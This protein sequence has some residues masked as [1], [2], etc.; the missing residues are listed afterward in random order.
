MQRAGRI[1]RDEL[2]VDL[3]A[4]AELAPAVAVTGARG[5][6][7]TER[8]SC[9]LGQPEIDEA[10]PGDLGLRTTVPSGSGARRAPVRQ[11]CGDWSS[12]GLATTMARLV[13]RSPWPPSRGR[14]STKAI[15]GASSTR[16]HPG[17]LGADAASLTRRPS[18]LVRLLG[19][20]PCG[21]RSRLGLSALALS[22]FGARVCLRRSVSGLARALAVLAVVGDVES[23]ALENEP[24]SP[25]NHARRRLCRTTGTWPRLLGH[26]L[27]LLERMPGGAPVLVRRHGL[28]ARGLTESA[29]KL[30]LD[31]L[32]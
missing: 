12:G 5:S 8:T 9:V 14:S 28:M 4:G 17:Q 26:P 1:G 15:S 30:S 16:G 31:E 13:A 19:F 25:G 29:T 2:D 27:E 20:G 22:G 23:A 32:R 3:W 18:W 10:G 7:A 24:R 6:A 11:L 21:R